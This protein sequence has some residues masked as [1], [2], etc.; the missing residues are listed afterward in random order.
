MKTDVLVVGSGI[1]GC[2]AALAAFREGADVLVVTKATEPE[3]ANTDWAQGGIAVTQSKPDAFAEDI[4]RASDDTADPEAV[5]VLVSEAREVVENVLL[6]TLGVEF[7]TAGD[8]FD[9]ARE[10]GHSNRRILH[11]DASTGKYVLRPFLEHL[12][13]HDGVRIIDD[14]MVLDLVSDEG[15]VRGATVLTDDGVEPV[16]AGATV[17]ATGGIGACYAQSTNPSGATGDGVAMAALAGATVSDMQYVQFHP[18]AY[19]PETDPSAEES[20]QPFLVSE[21]VRGEGAVLRDADG[22]RFMPD[23]HEDAELAPRDVVSRAVA[24]ARDQTGR[25]VLDVSDIDFRE[26]FPDL[27]DL[28]DDRGVDLDAGI[29]VAPSE[30][31]LCGGIAVDKHGQTS[32]DRLFAAGECARTGVHGANRLASTSLLEGLVWG[33]RAGETAAAQGRGNATVVEYSPPRDSDPALPD[34]FADAKFARLGKTMDE[35][36]GVERTPDGLETA[37]LRLRRLKGEVDAYART[38][39][40]RSLYE[41]R[42]ACISSLLVARAAASAPSAGCHSLSDSEVTASADD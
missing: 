27:A 19:D 8:D 20:A 6:D 33:T 25:V 22:R 26:A 14:A 23:V 12:S 40:S 13:D 7:D 1:A 15:T 28:C 31:F 16:F 36:V 35:F 4:R 9:L 30:H 32:L 11:V 21:A 34:A 2:A 42:N 29:P 24:R 10:A 39:V 38:R 41:L 3:D 37:R 5:D 17:L 18:T